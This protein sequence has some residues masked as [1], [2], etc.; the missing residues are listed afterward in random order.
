MQEK[1]ALL[2]SIQNKGNNEKN[3]FNILNDASASYLENV[4]LSYGIT[5]GSHLESAKDVISARQAQEIARSAIAKAKLEKVISSEQKVDGEVK[6]GSGDEEVNMNVIDN[7]T[8]GV[9]GFKL[10]KRCRS[11][12]KSD[13][14][15]SRKYKS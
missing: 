13:K 6:E 15:T 2:K 12:L 4:A 3:P 11:R 1:A 14:I 7:E 10:N 9:V 8:R 5:L